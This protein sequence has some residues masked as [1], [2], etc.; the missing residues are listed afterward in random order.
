MAPYVNEAIHQLEL[1]LQP[2][3][4]IDKENF[5][6]KVGA[7]L[8]GRL[9][10]FYQL[11]LF[12]ITFVHT[13]PM[14][15]HLMSFQDFATVFKSEARA[16]FRHT[17]QTHQTDSYGIDTTSFRIPEQREAID[18]M[19]DVLHNIEHLTTSFP[20]HESFYN[21]NTHRE[22]YLLH[23]N[24][25]CIG[26]KGEPRAVLTVF[27]IL[28]AAEL[29][30]KFSPANHPYVDIFMEEV[31]RWWWGEGEFHENFPDFEN[32]LAT[33]T[34]EYPGVFGKFLRRLGN[35]QCFED[36]RLREDPRLIFPYLTRQSQTQSWVNKVRDSTTNPTF[37]NRGPSAMGDIGRITSQ[38][39][40]TITEDPPVSTEQN[41]PRSIS[42]YFLADFSTTSE[43]SQEAEPTTTASAEKEALA[44]APSKSTNT[45]TLPEFS[46]A[47][48]PSQEDENEKPVAAQKDVFTTSPPR[49][50]NTFRVPD[51]HIG[52]S[53]SSDTTDNNA[54]PPTL[55][56]LKETTASGAEQIARTPSSDISHAIE[57][58]SVSPG[59]DSASL[60][61]RHA[62]QKTPDGSNHSPDNDTTAARTK[63]SGD[64]L[65]PPS[66]LHESAQEQSVDISAK[67]LP[68][69][70][71]PS[72]KA[73]GKKTAGEGTSTPSVDLREP[74]QLLSEETPADGTLDTTIIQLPSA[75]TGREVI[76]A[77]PPQTSLPRRSG[78]QRQ[79][80]QRYASTPTQPHEAIKSEREDREQARQKNQTSTP[81]SM[82]SAQRKDKRKHAGLEKAL[83]KTQKQ[84][85][86]GGTA[87]RKRPAQRHPPV[88]TFASK[89]TCV[90]ARGRVRKVPLKYGP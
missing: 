29:L 36:P 84:A 51:K 72:P 82:N 44:V 64:S 74:P 23:R 22:V 77:V 46:A 11:Y 19:L 14:I 88:V 89:S 1:L 54:D 21:P 58:T 48:E 26:M 35:T 65:S 76:P 57:E 40:G 33:V 81:K 49:S 67:N 25:H 70:Q 38:A 80:P 17:Q 56:P 68:A 18:Y 45:S 62:I 16:F 43:S 12:A 6:V 3:E 31:V 5:N 79:P 8:N 27:R 71:E 24:N 9:G 90:S 7:A 66:Q 10:A 85:A 2:E 61:S 20:P 34:N 41:P 32:R 55:S 60:S 86:K 37:H 47:S 63:D 4:T 28:L 50:T 75:A 15:P 69:S 78:R 83:T 53:D 52:S 30:Q 42:T 87:R 59:K 73:I 13:T 39:L